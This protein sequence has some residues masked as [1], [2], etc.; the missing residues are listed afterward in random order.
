MDCRDDVKSLEAFSVDDAM[1][2]SVNIPQL[3][4]EPANEDSAELELEVL[5]SAADS[6]KNGKVPSNSSSSPKPP[7]D[8]LIAVGAAITLSLN[9]VV[10]EMMELK[11][12]I[13]DA[14]CEDIESRGGG[15]MGEGCCQVQ[16]KVG[17]VLRPR[18][19]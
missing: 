10:D 4:G 7:F 18:V 3:D 8:S 16:R 2:G 13:A 6:S 17:D 15:R 12:S 19:V 11:S 14:M 1:R 9:D 5:P